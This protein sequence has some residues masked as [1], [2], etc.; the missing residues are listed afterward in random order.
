MSATEF[1]NLTFDCPLRLLSRLEKICG[2]D[3]TFVHFSTMAGF[4]GQKVEKDL[5][6]F[7]KTASISDPYTWTKK[8]LDCCIESNYYSGFVV[9]LRLSNLL[10]AD[11]QTSQR[12][13]IVRLAKKIDSGEKVEVARNA[14]LDF[15][16]G[17]QIKNALSIINSEKIKSK[18]INICNGERFY[19]LDLLRQLQI[20]LR[21]K[22]RKTGEI[23]PVGPVGKS[24]SYFEPIEGIGT[25]KLT[26]LQTELLKLI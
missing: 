4:E 6:S 10:I 5:T 8:L 21:K 25:V 1:L 2:Q 19:L 24:L 7:K 22:N 18:S 13:V 12:K 20:A 15:I 26:E 23:V 14:Q 9:N 11:Y 17:C 3:Y 16:I